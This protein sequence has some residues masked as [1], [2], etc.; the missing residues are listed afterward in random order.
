MKTLFDS[1]WIG[2]LQLRNRLI[3]SATWEAMADEAGRPT[4]RLIRVYRE[5]AE[6]G[7][8]LIVTSATTITPDSTRLPGMLSLIDEPG[9]LAFRDLTRAVHEGGTPIVMQLAFP[10]RNGAMWMPADGARDELQD[11]VQAFSDAAAR[12]HQAGFDGVQVRAAHGYF[13]SRFLNA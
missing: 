6:G 9:I 2:P 5:L 13:L 12:A 10:G 1:T 7:T 11:I 4:P 3:R 8:G